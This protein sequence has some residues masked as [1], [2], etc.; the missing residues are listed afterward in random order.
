M[1]AAYPSETSTMGL[2]LIVG[3]VRTKQ[4]PRPPQDPSSLVWPI[5]SARLA[6]RASWYRM[7]LR[8]T[9]WGN[10]PQGKRR[11]QL[12]ASC[13]TA[14]RG[15]FPKKADPLQHAGQGQDHNDWSHFTPRIAVVEHAPEHMVVCGIKGAKGLQRLN[16][17]RRFLRHE[18]TC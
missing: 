12:H 16:E 10:W 8:W 13:N 17:L 18:Y 11:V 7:N 1:A 14:W 4:S 9:R 6:P 3:S 2:S 5:C 15:R